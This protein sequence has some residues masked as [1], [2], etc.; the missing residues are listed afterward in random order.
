MSESAK[1]ATKAQFAL[2]EIANEVYDRGDGTPSSVNAVTRRDLE[3]Y[4]D[5]L[6][7][8]L[9]PR[10][11]T[12][13]EAEILTRVV[14]REKPTKQTLPLLWALVSSAM[15]AE[16]GTDLPQWVGRFIDVLRIAPPGYLV[17]LVDAAERF[18]LHAEA[19]PSQSVA[20]HL[21]AVNLI[22]P[23]T[24]AALMNGRVEVGA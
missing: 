13:D 9:T 16:Y 8:E 10:R 15:H 11:L 5:L 6:D 22:A 12:L 20:D 21:L 1:A 2:T 23:E 7:R 18:E 24:Y 4:Y 3:R 14:L 17:A 19:Y